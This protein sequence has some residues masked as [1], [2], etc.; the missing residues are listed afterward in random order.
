MSFSYDLEETLTADERRVDRIMKKLKIHLY[1]EYYNHVIHDFFENKAKMI[2]SELYKIFELM[3][4]GGIHNLHLSGAS[5]ADF[6]LKLSYE[7]C[8]YFSQRDK[9]FKIS[10][11]RFTK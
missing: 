1:D 10:R 4:K 11:V 2:N 3:P 7:D 9:S 8:V 6:F 5:S